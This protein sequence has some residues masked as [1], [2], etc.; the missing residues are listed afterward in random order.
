MPPV[1][2]SATRLGPYVSAVIG[3]F[4]VVAITIGVTAYHGADAAR[5][6]RAGPRVAAQAVAAEEPTRSGCD[7]PTRPGRLSSAWH[8]SI[9]PSTTRS[10]GTSHSGYRVQGS[11]YA[12]SP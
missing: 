12:P 11:R 2:W 6:M 4:A 7:T 3:T 1:A 8:L 5:V 9:F 10:G